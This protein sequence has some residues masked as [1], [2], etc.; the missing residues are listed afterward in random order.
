M[1]N[2]VEK[3]LKRRFVIGSQVSEH[4]IV[5]DFTRQV[6]PQFLQGPVHYCSIPTLSFHMLT[7]F[8]DVFIVLQLSL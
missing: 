4:A 6:R 3:Q 8:E 7:D 5:Q 2:R 1:L